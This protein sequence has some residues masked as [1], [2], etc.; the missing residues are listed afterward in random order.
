MRYVTQFLTKVYKGGGTFPKATARPPPKSRR[1][2][3][4]KKKKLPDDLLKWAFEKKNDLARK[5]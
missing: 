3:L 2:L 1:C 5:K 4:L